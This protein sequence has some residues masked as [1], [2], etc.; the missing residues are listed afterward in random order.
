MGLLIHG[1]PEDGLLEAENVATSNVYFN[2]ILELCLT[3]F[4]VGIPVY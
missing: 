1:W 2:L 3:D 4:S